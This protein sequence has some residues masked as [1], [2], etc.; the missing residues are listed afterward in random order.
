MRVFLSTSFFA[1]RALFRW[2]TVEQYAFQK[3]LY[4]LLQ[5]TFFA[6]VGA[7]ASARPLTFYLIG[8]AIVVAFRPLFAVALAVTEERDQG[9]LPYLLVSPANRVSLFFGRATLNIVDGAVDVVLAFVFA[10]LVFGLI[11]PASALPGLAAAVLMASACGAGLG[12]FLGAVAYV[13][14]DSLFLANT[15]MFVLLLVSGANI[16]AADLPP[17]LALLG[18]ILPLSRTIE[19]SRLYASGADFAS[20]VPLLLGDLGLAVAWSIAG[21]AVFSW[22]EAEAR[23]RGTFQ[24]I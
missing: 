19:A 10:V 23:R 6:F 22:V 8:N 13:V 7:F 17:S 9:T 4:P 15:A 18:Q 14:M 21:F 12:F 1:Y 2:L 3:L 24:G 5:L 11:L 20:G 16:P